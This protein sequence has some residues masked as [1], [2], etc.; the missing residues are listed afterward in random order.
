MFAVELHRAPIEAR[1][2]RDDRLRDCA[3]IIATLGDLL[4]AM[5][6]AASDHDEAD[7]VLRHAL[8]LGRV[9]WLREGDRALAA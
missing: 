8:K 5:R 3:C 4:E 1:R 9:S 2:G 7:R 6:W